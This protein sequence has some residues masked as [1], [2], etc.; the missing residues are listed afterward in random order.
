M[1]CGSHAPYMDIHDYHAPYMD[2][3]DYHAPYMDIHDYH[4]DTRNQSEGFI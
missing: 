1:A 2:I 3:H 4:A